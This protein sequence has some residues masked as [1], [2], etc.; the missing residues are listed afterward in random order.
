MRQLTFLEYTFMFDPAVAWPRLA[1]FENLL[2]KFFAEHNFEADKI[3]AIGGSQG[4]RILY[5]KPIPMINIPGE[6]KAVGRPQTVKGK[7]REMKEKKIS[8]RERDFGKRKVKGF[9][10]VL[11]K[12]KK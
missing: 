5:L 10:R 4:R 7:I 11:N 8:A 3:Q 9:E 2:A 12:V 1:D 6:R